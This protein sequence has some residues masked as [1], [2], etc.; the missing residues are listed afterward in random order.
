MTCI[1]NFQVLQDCKLKP[2]EKQKIK[3]FYIV[4]YDLFH[5]G[6]Y[7]SPWGSILGIPFTFE[8]IEDINFGELKLVG[9]E[10]IDW[11]IDGQDLIKA[12]TISD[13]AKK[14]AL[15][16]EI[17]SCDFS[18]ILENAAIGAFCVLIPARLAQVMN[19][20]M[21]TFERFSFKRRCVWYMGFY[22]IGFFFYRS[23]K[24]PLKHLS[25][26]EADR[27]AAETGPD[28]LNGGIEYYKK[29]MQ[30]NKAL[31]DLSGSRFKNKFDEHG[32]ENYFLFAPKIPISK[33]LENLRNMKEEKIVKVEK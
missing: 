22:A 27:L 31:R 33:R 5:A 24:D 18:H 19:T 6:G 28:Y 30:R 11:V 17:Y 23:F 2:E 29:A 15:M 13:N 9:R 1:I 25:D 14:F 21:K 26:K 20:K 3:F 4:G 16:R 10:T 32:N 8:P 7:N 12:M